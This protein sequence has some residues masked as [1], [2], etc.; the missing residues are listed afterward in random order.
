[1]PLRLSKDESRAVTFIGLLLALSAG[2]RLLDRPA[3]VEVE[4]PGVDL[5]ELEAASRRKL[6]ATN[7][8]PAGRRSAGTTQRPPAP[9][10]AGDPGRTAARGLTPQPAQPLDINRASAEELQRLPGIGVVIAA[11]IVAY[12]DSVGRFGSVEQLEG[13]RGIGPAMMRRL[14]PLVRVG[15]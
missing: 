10:P 2:A 6:E 8:A 11:R 12:R 9:S 5:V 13:V 15:S 1:M 14:T 7:A 4:G 3:P